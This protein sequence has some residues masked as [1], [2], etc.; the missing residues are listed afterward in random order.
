MSYRLSA[1]GDTYLLYVTFLEIKF[2]YSLYMNDLNRQTSEAKYMLPKDLR[3]S[4]MLRN[5]HW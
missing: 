1:I 3:S 4:E 2:L 5:V